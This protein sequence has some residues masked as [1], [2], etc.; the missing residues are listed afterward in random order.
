MQSPVPFCKW[1][2]GVRSDVISQEIEGFGSLWFESGMAISAAKCVC[3]R[4]DWRC[5]A[6][7]LDGG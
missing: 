6:P 4:L 2:Q 3:A 7:V 5:S 1:E